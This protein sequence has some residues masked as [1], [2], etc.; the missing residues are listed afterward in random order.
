MKFSASLAA[1]LAVLS[2][3]LD[4]PRSDVGQGLRQLADA[5]AVAVPS[6]L[7]L[8][9]VV[10]RH[11]PV[12]TVTL[13]DDDVTASDIGTSIV[14]A[15]PDP[16]DGHDVAAVAI[17]LYARSP[18]AFVDL[19]ADASWL[20]G[21]PLTDFP[22]DAHLAAAANPDT[23]TSLEA[24]SV[25]NQAVGVLIGRGSTARQAHWELDTQAAHSGTDRLAVARLILA[26][27]TPRGDNGFHIR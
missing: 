6:Y 2:A 17:I 22:L 12:F 11:D 19:A 10:T 16:G 26:R 15:W 14:L 21:R 18:G 13:F 1:E 3:A 7:G 25:T 27:L 20:T 5:V 4:E 23:A 24:A 8:T 9:A